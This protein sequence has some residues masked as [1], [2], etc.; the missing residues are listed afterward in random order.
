MTPWQTRA[1]V[2]DTLVRPQDS[3]AVVEDTVAL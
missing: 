1:V 3:R 2:M